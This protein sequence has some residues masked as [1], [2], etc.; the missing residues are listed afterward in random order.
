VITID[1]VGHSCL[2]AY[3]SRPLS[4]AHL[5]K[6]SPAD[7]K[8]RRLA[9]VRASRARRKLADHLADVARH[10]AGLA[11]GRDIIDLYA[12]HLIDA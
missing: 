11:P 6:L 1:M 3:L 8:A 10:D 12:Y 9:Q 4:P 2:T 5:A 7:R